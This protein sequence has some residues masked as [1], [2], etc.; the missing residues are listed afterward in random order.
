MRALGF[1]GEMGRDSY[2]HFF[3]LL[4]ETILFWSLPHPLLLLSLW[5]EMRGIKCPYF[6]F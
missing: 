6:C 1:M 4:K 2:C 5:D 3:S